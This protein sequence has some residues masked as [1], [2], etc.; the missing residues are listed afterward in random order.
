MR[1][2]VPPLG[3]GDRG[4]EVANLQEAL[5]L[6][7]ERNIIRL[8]EADRRR[9]IELLKRER[10][11]NIYGDGTQKIVGIFQQQHQR[12]ATGRVDEP[13]AKVL[14]L[15][16]RELGAIP[17][18]AEEKTYAVT[19]RIRSRQRA[20]TGGLRVIVVDKNAGEGDT[21]LVESATE[22]GGVYRA[23]FSAALFQRRGKTAPDLQARAF[24]GE[25]FLGASDVR[26][27]A[28]Q[29]ETLDI[30]LP[31]QAAAALSSEH[32]TLT[33]A[34]AV[35]FRGALRDL[36]ETD[37]REDVTYLAN[38]TGWDARAVALAALADQFSARTM[39]TTG[40]PAIAP[41]FFY[42]LFRAGLPANEDALYQTDVK[43]AESVW[44]QAIEQGVIPSALENQVSQALDHFQA[45]AAQRALDV[46]ALAGVSPLKDLLSLSLGEGETQQKQFAELYTRHR[47]DPPEFW[48]AVRDTFGE[49]AEMRLKLDG[50]L[51]YL[52]LNNATLIGRL[53]SAFGQNGLTDTVGLVR[54]GFYHPEKWQEVIAEGAIPPQ[55]PG[56]NEEEKRA[57]YAELLSTQVR[58]S[59]PTAVVAQM[60]K[61]GEVPLTAPASIRDGV[62]GFLMEEQ[63]KFEIGMQPVEQY[64]AR[65]NQQIDPEVTKEVK[66]IQRVY[67]ITP[68]DTAMNVLLK[69]GL[70]SAYAV[71]R[72]GQEEFVQTFKEDLGG[73]SEARLIYA[74][75]QQVHNTV[76]NIAAS[77]LIASTAPGIGVHSPA[78]I[79][80]PAPKGPHLEAANAGDVIAYPTLEAL[81]GEMDYCTC[82]HC[83]SILSPAAYLVDLLLFCDRPA[84][85]KENPL[86]V[87]LERRPDIQH[88]PL[89]CENTNT[90]VP[91]I[92]LANETLEY[93]VTNNLTL[94]NYTGHSTDG[95]A[96]SE[97]LLA[98]PQFVS[99]AAYATLKTE[100]FPPP[101]PFHQPLESL[102]RYFDKFEA[103]L[104]RVME[105]LRKDD[106]IERANANE[107]GWRDILIEELRLSRAEYALLTDRTLTLQQL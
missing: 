51:G 58:L 8:D 68:S 42:A 30:V 46:P 94:D 41:A 106:S 89:T 17:P 97:E 29:S 80:D 62:H 67:Q 56:A 84:N 47:G 12:E 13:T 4:D 71:V 14:N 50:Q 96:S 75:A 99:D 32:E 88:L 87:L 98:S 65:T 82:E 5:F 72:Y 91:Y 18:G 83:R 6:L 11:A 26:Y 69:K 10:D 20:G 15:I 22:D 107:Y 3:P 52:T 7:I 64:L 49:A 25:I 86:T 73:E 70:D 39:D 102:R 57:R 9:W 28:A 27:N 81:F 90:L 61:S 100:L 54:E 60:V 92:D 33:A 79:I 2:I 53:R 66:R 37:G 31:E 104:P 34:L 45:L 101:L 21:R 16:L 95:A 23:T 1:E 59:F 43:T 105:A 48:K 103:P 38:K 85:E 40:A 77:Y 24:R 78:G 93:F 55:I 74:K 76:L 19:G 44:K 36:K 63:G 35:H